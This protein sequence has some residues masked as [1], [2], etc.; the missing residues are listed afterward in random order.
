MASVAVWER[1]PKRQKFH[2]LLKSYVLISYH[3]HGG[4]E[5]YTPSRCPRTPIPS[6]LQHLLFVSCTPRSLPAALALWG[7]PGPAGTPRPRRVPV[8]CSPSLAPARRERQRFWARSGARR[9]PAALVWRGVGV[10]PEPA[11][12]PA[13]APAPRDTGVPAVPGHKPQQRREPS[14]RA[15]R[16]L[17]SWAFHC[18]DLEGA[19]K[20]ML[21]KLGKLNL[22]GFL[23]K[24]SAR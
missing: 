12:A 6:P 11:D 7:H 19:A 8:L 2:R 16:R 10:T 14:S 15:P 4:S 24:Q 1:A 21:C 3:C 17:E 20:F 5:E 9:W 13:A 22:K 23:N 18:P